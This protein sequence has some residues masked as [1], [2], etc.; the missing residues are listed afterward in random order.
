MFESS[1][2]ERTQSTVG[3]NTSK[4]FSNRWHIR[5][6]IPPEIDLFP[7]TGFTIQLIE[8]NTKWFVIKDQGIREYEGFTKKPDASVVNVSFILQIN[9]RERI[10]FFAKKFPMFYV[11]RRFIT[12]FARVCHFLP[13][14]I[15]TIS[16]HN[17]S[18]HISKEHLKFMLPATPKIST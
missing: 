16:V 14:L 6:R 15:Y 8:N 18:P 12:V 4:A 5:N 13:F 10:F 3:F 11:T 7:G 2:A 9:S 1:P 17:L